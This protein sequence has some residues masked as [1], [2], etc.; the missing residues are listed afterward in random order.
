MDAT[1]GKNSNKIIQEFLA[2]YKKDKEKIGGEKIK[3]YASFIENIG[4]EFLHDTLDNMQM[5]LKNIDFETRMKKV[6]K[7]KKSITKN[8]SKK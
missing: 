8:N 5:K 6:L 2:D 7:K 4:D 1:I 3:F